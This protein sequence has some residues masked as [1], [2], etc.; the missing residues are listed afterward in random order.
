[1]QARE[2]STGAA[3][4]IRLDL[5]ALTHAAHERVDMAFSQLSLTEPAGYATFLRAHSAVLPACE[6]ALTASGAESFLP[7]WPSRVRA[8]ALRA[9][10]ATIGAQPGAEIGDI[11]MLSPAAAFGMM[12]V[13]EGSRL[14]GA[15]LA[16]RLLDNPDVRCRAASRYL[17]HGE[18]QR[19]WPSFV[20]A[21][22]SSPHVRADR[23]ST[24]ASALQ[25][26]ALFEAAANNARDAP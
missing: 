21:L 13:L 1:L 3:N 9:D 6:R 23:Q 17:L 4:A 25:A 7:D 16:R 12:Y 22:E 5:R 26:F 19:L 18:G 24:I 14:G 10:L 8:P 11:G 2:H 15:I 20:A